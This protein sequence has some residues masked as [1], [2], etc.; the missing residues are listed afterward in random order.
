MYQA[1]THLS[2]EL[3]LSNLP[4]S[5]GC[6][7]IFLRPQDNTFITVSV[8]QFCSIWGKLGT[9]DSV[10]FFH[11]ELEVEKLANGKP[12]LIGI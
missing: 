8:L 9:F 6:V 5:F 10:F 11:A 2:V 4:K 1:A 7:V 3:R 12:A